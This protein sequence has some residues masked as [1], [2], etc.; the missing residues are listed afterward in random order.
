VVVRD[1]LAYEELLLDKALPIRLNTE[2]DF[3]QYD[4]RTC[5]C[6]KPMVMRSAIPQAGTGVLLRLCCLAQQF[7]DL[8]GVPPGTFYQVF[9]FEPSWEWDC[10]AV[11]VT[12]KGI[13]D[14]SDEFT[15][16]RVG[17]PPEWI[18]KRMDEKGIPIKNRAGAQ[19]GPI[20]IRSWVEKRTS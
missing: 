4:R 12:R 11:S 13:G 1:G 17:L 19:R 3:K 6:A 2:E 16:Y 14:G 7:E 5:Q 10:E 18:E 8:L 9:D 20:F 15:E